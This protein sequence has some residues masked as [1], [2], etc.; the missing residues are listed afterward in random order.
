MGKKNL[1]IGGIWIVLFLALGGFLEMKLGTAG[2]EWFE[3]SMRSF[4]KTAHLHGALFGILNILYALLIK[5]YR[6]S[7]TFV[8]AGS[9]LAVVAAVIF[10]VALFAAGFNEAL[11]K[12]APLGGASM[13]LAWVAMAVSLFSAN[14][15]D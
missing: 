15:E 7:G 4:M 9:W 1:I 3:S 11:V 13:I 6:L 5:N 8:S 14:A 2:P 12:V 10:P